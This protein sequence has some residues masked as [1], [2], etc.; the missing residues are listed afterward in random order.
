MPEI[1]FVDATCYGNDLNKQHAKL[2]KVPQV[3]HAPG[4]TEQNISKTS[5]IITSKDVHSG[6]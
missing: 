1:P 6:S 3:H 5:P 2:Q 4:S